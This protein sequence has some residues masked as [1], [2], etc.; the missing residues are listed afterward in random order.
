[1]NLFMTGSPRELEFWHGRHLQMA[2]LALSVQ[3]MEM[4]LSLAA[5]YREQIAA[6]LLGTA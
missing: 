6:M 3:V 5:L 4:H 1:M 2:A